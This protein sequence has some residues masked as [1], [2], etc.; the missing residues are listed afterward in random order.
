MADTEEIL[1][2]VKQYLRI[3]YEDDDNI[4]KIIIETSKEYIINSIG[5]FNIEIAQM[6]ILLFAICAELYEERTFTVTKKV[7]K[8]YIVK[9]IIGQLSLKNLGD[10]K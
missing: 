3:D 5:Y 8:N 7:E 2:I 10:I 9:N 6:Q 1:N 4:L